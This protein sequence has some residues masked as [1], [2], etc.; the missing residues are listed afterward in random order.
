MKSVLGRLAL[1]C[2]MLTS[3]VVVGLV[4]LPTSAAQVDVAGRLADSRSPGPT[5]DGEYSGFG[6]TTPS[7]RIYLQVGGRAGVP[8]NAKSVALNVTAVN[9]RTSGFVT[10]DDCAASVP[11]SSNLNF[12]PGQTIA[13]LVITELNADGMACIFTNGVTDLVVDVAASFA[14]T[15]F[16][17]VAPGRLLETRSGRQTVDGQLQGGGAIG[18]GRSV[19]VDVAGRHEIPDGVDQV[20][21]NI[22][23]IQPSANG[24]MTAYECG[25]SVPTT[26]NLNFKA[27]RNI[28]RLSVVDISSDGGFCL[29][30]NVTSG[31]AVDVFGYFSKGAFRLVDQARL[32]DTRPG[33]ST[34]DAQ[35]QGVGRLAGGATLELDIAGRA[36][37]PADA[38]A[39]LLQVTAV[40]QTGRGYVTLHP[41]GS[42][43]PT[44]SN[45]NFVPGAAIGNTAIVE[46]GG[47]G[48]AC[49]FSSRASHIVVDVVGWFVGPK[50][51]TST[52]SCP[53]PVETPD[54]DIPDFEP[55]DG[56]DM[57]IPGIDPSR[58][59]DP[60]SNQLLRYN[61][62]E[63]GDFNGTGEVR[64][65]CGTSHHAYDDPIVAPGQTGASHLHTFFGNA[66]TD[67]D[68]TYESLRNEPAGST[69]AGGSVNKSA[70]WFP[71]L[72]DGSSK[73]VV[74]P[75]LAFVYYKTGYWGQDGRDIQDI[76]DGLRM[77][78]G[79]AS[80][81]GSD[82][83]FVSWA[84][85]R[86]N[87]DGVPLGTI[88]SGS[89]I[90]QCARNDLLVLRVT[91][92]Q[93]W[94]GRDLDS[95]NHKSHMAHPNFQGQC[96]ATHPV[97]LPQVQI[98]V[99]WNM[100]AAGSNSLYV[101]NDM[102]LPA[103]SPPGQGAHADFFEAWDPAA[104]SSFVQ[105]CLNA[106]RDCGVRAL[107]DGYTLID[108]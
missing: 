23:A 27:G 7:D 83:L 25:S 45:M 22:T 75:T 35:Q 72:I 65:T 102:M 44:A 97:L 36:G 13:N 89:S 93:C 108:P 52:E 24:Y 9:G 85:E 10:V 21:V 92:P 53:E 18:G 101:A 19:Q 80:G 96:P 49:L 60:S 95:A 2:S 50:S 104:R 11:N 77:I 70:Y 81:N 94:N 59:S 88:R 79:N 20:V 56:P 105:N 15:D 39:V 8:A 103:G 61:S 71:S 6:V 55:W 87:G 67:A 30:S 43:R 99:S 86:H 1:A 73:T 5:V 51:S 29:F 37:V 4:T 33:F 106:R 98:N 3:V 90:P 64:M 84:C 34:T 78:S 74:E 57:K 28:A 48:S 47:S 46:L 17:A 69:C 38:K 58:A 42:E 40:R 100:G 107:G 63:F 41:P 91:F 12:Q 32:V 82:D 26:S 31:A 14:A 54:D 68:S 62:G 76:P 66:G 16:T